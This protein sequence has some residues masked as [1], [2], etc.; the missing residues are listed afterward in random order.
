ML[1]FADLSDFKAEALSIVA[2]FPGCVRLYPLSIY[3]AYGKFG[4]P[5]LLVLVDIYLPQINN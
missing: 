5:K 1:S 3:S 4:H 2:S